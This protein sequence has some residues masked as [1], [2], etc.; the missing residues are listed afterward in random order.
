MI[1][2]ALLAICYLILLISL[3]NFFTIRIPRNTAEVSQ[4]VTIL[5]PMRNEELNAQDCVAGLMAQINVRKMQVIIIDD[6]SSDNTAE[7]LAKAIASDTRFSVIR[8]D[9]PQS[10]WLGKVSALQAGFEKS[11]GEIIICL[12][13]DVRLKPSA[14]SSAINQINELGLDFSSPY[15]HQ[16]ANTFAEKLIQPLL[17]WSW[18]STVILRLAEKS[19]RKSTAVANGQ[20]FLIRADALKSIGGF[21]AVS[22]Q[23]LDDIELARSLIGAGFKGSVTEGSEIAHT[24]MYANFDEIKQGYGKSLHKAFGGVSG[25]LLAVLF[26]AA[27]GIAPLALALT[28]N[29][30]GWVTYLLIAFTRALSARRSHSNPFYGLL[31]PLSAALLI[32]LIGY[33]W[34]QRGKIQWKGRTV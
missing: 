17:H 27:T 18:M 3:F 15:P 22:D 29:I 28:G 23:I 10:G 12:D 24:R 8:T 5:L 25:A 4:S 14:V 9:G 1:E 6:Q 21:R 11:N 20:L 31:H 34:S 33:S 19:P 13:A 30:V 2:L 26:I 16:I 32:Y 7:V